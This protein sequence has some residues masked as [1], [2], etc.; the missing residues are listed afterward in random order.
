MHPILLL[1]LALGAGLAFT[2]RSNASSAPAT[3]DAALIDPVERMHPNAETARK[4]IVNAMQVNSLSLYEQTAVAIETQLRMPLTAGHLRSWAAMA[5]QGG[6]AVAGSE[7]YG[8]DEVGASR[9]RMLRGRRGGKQMLPDWL[10]FSA[11]QSKPAGDPNLIKAT[12]K[13]MRRMGYVE[14]SEILLTES[15]G[16]LR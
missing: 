1:G 9:P 6:H 2:K 13:V 7:G 5:K 14:H 8:D 15:L 12:A 11:T 10:R 4:A 3:T 16:A